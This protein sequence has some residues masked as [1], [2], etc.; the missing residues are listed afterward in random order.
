MEYNNLWNGNKRQFSHHWCEK[1]VEAQTNEKYLLNQTN[2]DFTLP[3][4]RRMQAK[5]AIKDE[6]AFDFAELSP[7]YSGYELEI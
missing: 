1:L 6:Y 2:F 4:E 7:K 5:L 3:A